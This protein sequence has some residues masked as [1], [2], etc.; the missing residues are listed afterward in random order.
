M[1]MMDLP[2]WVGWERARSW[3]E[4]MDLARNRY[5]A[6][7][8][9]GHEYVAKQYVWRSYIHERYGSSGQFW[10]V[11]SLPNPRSQGGV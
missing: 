4:A 8:R 9:A 6:T 11:S 3:P 7:V 10:I 5:E 2:P 1:Q